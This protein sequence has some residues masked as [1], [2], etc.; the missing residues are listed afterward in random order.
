M[1]VNKL[2]KKKSAKNNGKILFGVTMIILGIIFLNQSKQNKKINEIQEQREKEL[3]VQDELL[4]VFFQYISYVK[5][6]DDGFRV[7]RNA[8]QKNY[9]NPNISNAL[10]QKSL[11]KFISE[12]NIQIP[13]LILDGF[14]GINT[15]NALT[16]SIAV[17]S[18]KTIPTVGSKEYINPETNDCYTIKEVFN[19]LISHSEWKERVGREEL[20]VDD[21][22]TEYRDN[23]MTIRLIDSYSKLR[24]QHKSFLLHLIYWIRSS[25]EK[26]QQTGVSLVEI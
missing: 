5:T 22:F 4:D 14:L 8:F 25:Q 16:T 17:Y 7:T 12:A 1:A 21:K 19:L 3:Q 13:E 20:I 23:L 9:K 18:G 15:M 11:N 24:I 26:S 6:Y 2:K 10:L